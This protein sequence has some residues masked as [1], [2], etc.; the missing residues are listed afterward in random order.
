VRPESPSTL[1]EMLVAKN[2]LPETARI[3]SALLLRLPGRRAR[4][5]SLTRLHDLTKPC[6]IKS[7][8]LRLIWRL[9][10]GCPTSPEVFHQH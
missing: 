4:L 3:R 9:L 6:Q 10:F 1:G 5:R 7:E 2:I 8:L